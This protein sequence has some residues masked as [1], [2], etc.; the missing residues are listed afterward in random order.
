MSKPVG[1]RVLALASVR[2]EKKSR[3]FISAEEKTQS[4]VKGQENPGQSSRERLHGSR[5]NQGIHEPEREHHPS[6][7]S[8][9]QKRQ[10][11]KVTIGC[12]KEINSPLLRRHLNAT[13]PTIPVCEHREID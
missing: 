2:H 1:K 10:I 7:S 3:L 9:N 13:R 12:Q 4:D 5:F 8:Q 11:R 6:S